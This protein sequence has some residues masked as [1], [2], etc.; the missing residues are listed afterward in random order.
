MPISLLFFSSAEI[1]LPLFEALIKDERFEVKALFCQPDKPAGRNLQLQSPPTKVLAE[2]CGIPV[3]QPVKLSEAPELLSLYEVDFLLT[4]AYGQILNETWLNLPKVAPLNIHTSL[5]PKYRGASPIQSAILN[6]DRS[7]GYSLMKMVKAMDA[8]PVAFTH[9][10]E[11]DENMTAGELHD[12]M[13]IEAAAHVPDQIVQLKSAPHFI[14]QDESKLSFCHKIDR[15][16]G[17]L[18]FNKG[19]DELYARFK[20]YHPWPGA[21]TRFQGK[22]LKLLT[23][24]PHLK[25]LT[26]GVVAWEN[27]QL[28]IGTADGALEISELQLEGKRRLSAKD[29]LSGQSDFAEAVL[30]S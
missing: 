17:E 4:F 21:W 9:E 25:K 5:L 22:R 29:F 24:K 23:L 6:G 1:S 20:A 3:H 16:A 2:N 27:D 12:R 30:P 10:I 26:P 14:E 11:I 19:T 15:E 18:D 7:S 28:L 13:A 8:G